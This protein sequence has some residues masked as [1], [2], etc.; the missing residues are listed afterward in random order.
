MPGDTTARSL[1][2]FDRV[3]AADMS[4]STGVITAGMNPNDSKEFG[5]LHYMQ[6]RENEERGGKRK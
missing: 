3:L 4:D 1:S 6:L 5:Y 2:H